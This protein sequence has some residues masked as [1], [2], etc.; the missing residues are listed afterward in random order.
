MSNSERLTADDNSKSST[1]KCELCI[2]GFRNALRLKFP[3]RLTIH[4]EGLENGPCIVMQPT[5][6][7]RESVA[8]KTGQT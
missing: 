6:N 3:P 4:M 8:I 7:G 1:V 2:R 5:R